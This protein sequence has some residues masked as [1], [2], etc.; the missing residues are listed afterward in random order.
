MPTVQ[1]D[2]T[3]SVVPPDPVPPKGTGPG[4]LT[5]GATDLLLLL[6]VTVWGINYS[7]VKYGSQVMTPL[8]FTWVRVFISAVT[9]MTIALLRPIPWPSRRDILGLLGLGALGN[10]IYQLFFVLG[11]SQTR[12]AD[13]ALLG[14]SSP[15]VVALLSLLQGIERGRFRTFLGIAL[16][17]AGV[18]IVVYGSAEASNGQ[19]SWLGVG[20]VLISVVCWSLFT[21]LLRYYTLRVEPIQLH[22]IGMVGGMIPLAFVTPAALSGAAWGQVSLTTWLVVAYSSWLSMVLVYLFWF[23]GVKILGPTRTSIY[24]NL[25]PVVAIVFAWGVLHEAPTVW[26]GIGAATIIAGIVL[27]R[28]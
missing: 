15:M 12:V 3:P 23:R 6:T 16:S 24:S 14:A 1:A 11:V 28:M 17:I 8:A 7:A 20:L 19:G 22:A 18:G 4:T 25:Q 21:V 27:S 26:Q 2:S 5:F 9:L 13:A 10:G